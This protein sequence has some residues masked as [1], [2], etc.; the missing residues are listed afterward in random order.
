M[1][2]EV[3]AGDRVLERR[4]LAIVCKLKL[5]GLRSLV[6]STLRWKT[7]ISHFRKATH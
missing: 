5:S 3:V 1:G 2:V 7:V 4:P 6:N